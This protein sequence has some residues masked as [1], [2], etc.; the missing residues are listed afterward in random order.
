MCVK[1][2]RCSAKNGH[3]WMRNWKVNRCSAPAVYKAVGLLTCLATSVNQITWKHLIVC[4]EH[5]SKILLTIRVVQCVGPL[6]EQ[7][8]FSSAEN[9]EC[10]LYKMFYWRT[11]MY[12]ITAKQIHF[13]QND[14]SPM[15]ETLLQSITYNFMFYSADDEHVCRCCPFQTTAIHV[16]LIFVGDG[17][18]RYQCC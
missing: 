7:C 1:L 11:W 14:L 10:N 15:W 13:R 12:A 9:T 18:T 6:S 4:P 5:A 16:W 8:R 17:H 3:E 2:Q